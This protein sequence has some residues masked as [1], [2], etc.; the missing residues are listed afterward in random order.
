MLYFGVDKGTVEFVYT[1]IT[2]AEYYR[3]AY[4]SAQ[5]SLNE[6]DEGV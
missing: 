2:L 1:G 6:V 4:K 5:T 3:Q